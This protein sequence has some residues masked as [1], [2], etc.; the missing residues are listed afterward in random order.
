MKIKRARDALEAWHGSREAK[1]FGFFRRNVNK[2]S[3]KKGRGTSSNAGKQSTLDKEC[4]KSPLGRRSKPARESQDVLQKSNSIRQ[5]ESEVPTVT[6]QSDLGPLN[7][8]K[9]IPSEDVLT[10]LVAVDLPAKQDEK[11]EKDAKPD[12]NPP[13][14]NCAPMDAPR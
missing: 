14:Q 3:E 6:V 13:V 4:G 5:E 7:E 12:S 9:S 2:E 11:D 8:I 1:M 10:Q